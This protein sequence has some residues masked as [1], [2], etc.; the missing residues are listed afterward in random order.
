MS[1]SAFIVYTYYALKEAT[2]ENQHLDYIYNKLKEPTGE[3]IIYSIHIQIE[4]GHWEISTHS[5]H[6]L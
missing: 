5:I 6:I 1:K 4:G 3:I 2:C